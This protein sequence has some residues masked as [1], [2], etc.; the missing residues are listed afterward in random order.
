MPDSLI[1]VLPFEF[2][3][4]ILAIVCLAMYSMTQIRKGVGLPLLAVLTT[5]TVWYVGD[6]V[7]NNYSANHLV[8][9]PPAILA[10]GWMQVVIF[11]ASLFVGVAIVHPIANSDC[12]G[13]SSRVYFLSN[14]GSD[15][16]NSNKPSSRLQEYAGRS[17]LF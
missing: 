12:I 17:G 3:V 6:V 2:W 15:L 9:F 8:K 4:A 11:A 13:N 14:Q 16:A 7:Y 1:D 5:I 10:F